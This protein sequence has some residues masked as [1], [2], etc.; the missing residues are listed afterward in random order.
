LPQ[1]VDNTELPGRLNIDDVAARRRA[2]DEQVVA[3]FVERVRLA[4]VFPS[5]GAPV[6]SPHTVRELLGVLESLTRRESARH[7][8]FRSAMRSLQRPPDLNRPDSNWRPRVL[9]GSSE[10]GLVVERSE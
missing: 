10:P 9:C 3:T 1:G 5:E 4:A 2:L 8:A 7:R 6:L